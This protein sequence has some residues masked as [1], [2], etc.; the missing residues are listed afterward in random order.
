MKPRGKEAVHGR[1][2]QAQ[3]RCQGGFLSLDESCLLVGFLPSAR[4]LG[5]RVRLGSSPH[6]G[7]PGSLVLYESC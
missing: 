7:S 2:Q 6:V 4:E 1:R 3:E 5:L